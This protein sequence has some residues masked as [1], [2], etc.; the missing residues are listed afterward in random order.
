[1][2]PVRASEVRSTAE[3]SSLAADLRFG[4]QKRDPGGWGEFKIKNSKFKIQV[5]ARHTIV[6]ESPLI[7]DY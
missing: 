3:S 4:A 7:T 1:M 5:P 2:A 6:S